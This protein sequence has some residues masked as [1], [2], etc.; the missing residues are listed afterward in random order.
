MYFYKN[1]KF[2]KNL[3]LDSIETKLSKRYKQTAQYQVVGQLKSYISNRKNEF[4]NYLKSS[5]FDEET[6]TKLY[7]INK[8]EKWFMN[9]VKMKN[10]E[11]KQT[12]FDYWINLSTLEQGKKI[13]LPVTTNRYFEG[14][15]GT[16]KNFIQI[17]FHQDID[18]IN[19]NI[20]LSKQRNLDYSD[21]KIDICLVKNLK[22]T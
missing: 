4:K 3:K 15:D 14:I 17:N 21:Y 11:I 1:G 6:K 8:Y 12:S 7:Y 22:K 16:I 13:Y 10:E 9:S 2:D 5:N 20:P 19:G 18:K